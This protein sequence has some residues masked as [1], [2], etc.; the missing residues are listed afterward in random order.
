M[1]QAS[2]VKE[3]PSKT[4]NDTTKTDLNSVNTTTPSGSNVTSTTTSS[5]VSNDGKESK[6]GFIKLD[7][8]SW[9]R[10]YRGLGKGVELTIEGPFMD[11]NGQVVHR[12]RTIRDDK[13]VSC[14]DTPL[15]P[16][17]QP[18]DQP[19]AQTQSQNNPPFK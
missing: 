7:W 4:E 19:K 9:D 8:D 3:S 11:C 2:H 6:Q 5:L 13:I 10:G 15:P 17:A 1:S 14:I 16:P 18:K 12:I